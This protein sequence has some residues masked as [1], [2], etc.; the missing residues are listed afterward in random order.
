MRSKLTFEFIGNACG[1]F[2]G[3]D[4]TRVLCDPWIVNG[5]FEGSWCHYPPLETTIDDLRGVD[6]IFISH[7]HPDHFDERFFDYDKSMPLIVLDHP[8]NFLSR[9][10]ETLGYT[11]LIR[12]K[13]GERVSFK[14]FELVCFAPFAKHNFHEADVGNLI[15]SALLISCDGISAFNANDNTPTLESAADLVAQY[16][17]VNFAMLNYNAAGPYPSCFDN[18]SEQEKISEHNRI[19]TR[20][21]NH[22]VNVLNVMKPSH[23][24]PFA[25]AYVLGGKEAHKNKYLGTSTWDHCAAYVAAKNVA[26]NIVTL[27]EHDIFNI[28][29]GVADKK[30]IPIN[31]KAMA[32]YIEKEIA[33]IVYPHELDDAPPHEQLLSELE[34]ASKLMI[35]RMNRF[36]IEP[37]ASIYIQIYDNI[38]KIYPVFTIVDQETD[39]PSLS[40]RLDERLLSRILHRKAHWNNAE[41]GAHINFK[42]INCDYE[43]DL[44]MGLQFL[45]L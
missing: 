39:E 17:H 28:E 21:F 7:L 33:S 35:E 40:C 15:D 32:A 43:P 4:G 6:A 34:K 31:T 24:L 29:R 2:T 42:R 36:G 13:N 22:V 44:H 19:L 23:F 30:Y 14:E 26:A 41:I 8:P 5:V 10:L 1:I 18:L 11:N 12:V 9:K 16:G 3:K 37:K 45:H 27:R 38:A 25:G 20:N